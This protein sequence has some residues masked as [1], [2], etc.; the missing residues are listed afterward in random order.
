MPNQLRRVVDCYVGGLVWRAMIMGLRGRQG[1]F[2]NTLYSCWHS[3]F[4]LVLF[5][6]LTWN[7]RNLP[8]PADDSY[9]CRINLSFNLPVA[10]KANHWIQ[11]TSLPSSQGRLEHL[12]KVNLPKT[13]S[14]TKKAMGCKALKVEKCLQK[15]HALATCPTIFN[16]NLMAWLSWFHR[17]LKKKLVADPGADALDAVLA[18]LGAAC[19]VCREDFPAPED[20]EMCLSRCWAWGEL[21]LF[22]NSE[23]KTGWNGAR[24]RLWSVGIVWSNPMSEINDSMEQSAS[25]DLCNMI[26]A[27]GLRNEDLMTWGSKT[28]ETAGS[29]GSF[30]VPNLMQFSS[31]VALPGPGLI[32]TSLRP[33]FIVRT[34][35]PW[36]VHQK[37]VGGLW[38]NSMES[39]DRMDSGVRLDAF[40][41]H[42]LS[43]WKY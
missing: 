24:H 14:L 39:I 37:K 36:S 42:F 29:F 32:S 11:T 6:H 41:T 16:E 10:L 23:R 2:P 12:V 43:L 19:S 40:R 30:W 34:C 28:N 33:V 26:L 3:R 8:T 15:T 1:E 9:S 27:V 4:K 25:D 7:R 18:A 13:P 35:W 17:Q 21:D 5:L 38:V 22:P 31:R 20:G